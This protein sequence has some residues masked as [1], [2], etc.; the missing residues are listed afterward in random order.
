MKWRHIAADEDATNRLGQALAAALKPGTVVALCGDLGAG[1]TRLVQS[2]METLGVDRAN[3]SSPTFV[4]VQEYQADFPV[5]HMDVYRLK[6]V[7]EFIELG[8]TELLFGE[9]VCLIEWAERVEEI[10]PPDLLVIRITA[11]GETSREF[12]FE[13]TG[14]RSTEVFRAICTFMD[15]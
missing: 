7:D 3:V 14:E 13:P 4:L 11:T 6:D 15:P 9:G 8:A 2:V 10:L 5:Y 1:K 12:S